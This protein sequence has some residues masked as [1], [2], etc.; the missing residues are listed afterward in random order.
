[1]FEDEVLKRLTFSACPLNNIN[2]NFVG[3]FMVNKKRKSSTLPERSSKV[4]THFLCIPAKL[5]HI[6]REVSPIGRF[7]NKFL[8]N[9]E[10]LIENKK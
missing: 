2:K 10:T 5:R 6:R 4:S 9:P 1:M 7:Q 8:S 3:G